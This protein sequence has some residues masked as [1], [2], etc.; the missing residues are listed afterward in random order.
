MEMM[1]KRTITWILIGALA[2]SALCGCVWIPKE[3]VPASGEQETV[4]VHLYAA[5]YLGKSK[6][7]IASLLGGFTEETYYNGGM[8]YKFSRSDMWFWFGN[9]TAAFADV[10]E[11]AACCFVMAP[12]SLAAD[13]ASYVVSEEELSETLGFS[14]GEPSYNEMDEMYN[15][16]ATENGVTCIVS[17]SEDG[18]A[19]VKDDY[20]TYMVEK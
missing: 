6:A 18:I 2:F 10:P 17:C 1:M 11:D 14:F 8:I 16:I 4:K 5:D 7:E 19:S 15:Y 12:L 9:D 13:F 20:I 3:T